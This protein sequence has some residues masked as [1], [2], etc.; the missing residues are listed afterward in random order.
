M[1]HAFTAKAAALGYEVIDLD[2][3][4]FADFGQ[5][6]ERFEIPG[7]GHWT[8]NAHGGV[9]GAVRASR[10][11]RRLRAPRWSGNCRTS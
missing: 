9:A 5:R 8:A 2:P 4:F 1:R 10:C 3:H 7:D 11:V 6:G